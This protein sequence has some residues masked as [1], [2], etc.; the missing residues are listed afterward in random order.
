MVVRVEGR[1]GSGGAGGV[2]ALRA[3]R[4]GGSC[5][6]LKSRLMGVSAGCPPTRTR[7]RPRRGTQPQAGCPLGMARLQ[8]PADRIR[9]A[10]STIDLN[11][12]EQEN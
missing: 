11:L 2:G 10:I 7:S 3:V 1:A 8:S 5:G 4:R 12:Q 9:S 6:R